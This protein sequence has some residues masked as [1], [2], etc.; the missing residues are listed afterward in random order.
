MADT[1]VG[2]DLVATN[3]ASPVINQ[4]KKSLGGL[5]DAAGTLSQGL[6]GLAGA[7]GVGSIVAI[8]TQIGAAAVQMT[9]LAERSRIVSTS[10]Q[11]LAAS[12]GQSA[13]G[14][15][16]AMKRAS[17]G[18]ISEY[19]LM[20]AANKAMMLGVAQNAGE[21]E[22]ILKVA[23]SRGAAMGLT[24][25][26]AFDDL[27]TG[28][29][30]GSA[31][32]LDNLGITM[33]SL[34][35]A[36]EEYARALGKTTQQLSDQEKKQA[37]VNAVLK[38]SAA[39]DPSGLT[40]MAGGMERL[41]AA[42]ADL[43][44]A[45][46]QDLTPAVNG[47]TGMTADLITAA[48]GVLEYASA[49]DILSTSINAM[50]TGGNSLLPDMLDMLDKAGQAANQVSYENS[51][52][53]DVVAQSKENQLAQEQ[54]NAQRVA[55]E[56]KTADA[57]VATQ[58]NMYRTM[59]NLRTSV[60]NQLRDEGFGIEEAWE[61]SNQAMIEGIAAYGTTLQSIT[62]DSLRLEEAKRIVLDYADAV[63][64]SSIK[65]D[66]IASRAATAGEVTQ[67]LA[68]KT[69]EAAGALWKGSDAAERMGASLGMLVEAAQRAQNALVF[70]RA[71]SSL[72]SAAMGAIDTLGAVAAYNLYEDQLASL[73]DVQ[74]AY[75]AQGKEGV[76][77]EF[78]MQ[79]AV[80]ERTARTYA[81]VNGINAAKDAMNSGTQAATNYGSALGNIKAPD[82]GSKVSGALQSALNLNV[83]V[84]PADYM[85]R[86]DAANEN[87]RR[88]ASIMVE[89]MNGQSWMGEFANEVPDIY[90]QLLESQ[91]PSAA[92]AKLLT[93]FQKGLV[94]QLIDKETIMQQV[95]DALM[96]EANMAA[97]AQEITQ[98]LVNQGMGDPTQIQALVNQSMGLKAGQTGT[99]DLTTNVIGQLKSEDFLNG[100]KG[101]GGT[102]ATNWGSAF[103]ASVGENVPMALILILAQLVAPILAGNQADDASRTGAQ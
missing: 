71:A 56:Q 11:G 18:T 59:D 51:F 72:Q 40:N 60:Y 36:E 65:M 53:N 78:L 41:R 87:A 98:D 93:D 85:P 89:G 17:L 62:V 66:S 5:E 81:L 22:G 31:L 4:V 102:A 8:A 97:L 58:Q 103:L 44:V 90:A 80:E 48:N 25:A 2:I 26:Q 7:A 63:V 43:Q 15:L 20:L 101:A 39:L 73:A 86:P 75:I 94:P 69:N 42:I 96:G 19:D 99:G 32:I 83:G 88:L 10:M 49:L 24:T 67:Q 16:D 34:K 45:V 77:L 55:D 92:A 54:A 47:I 70:D 82:I 74:A 52:V 33:D 57:I 95:K 12:F 91:D 29:G 28:L 3:R 61:Q 27:V 68:M 23:M 79:A 1:R 64:E 21:L 13:D 30:R 6:G 76:E 84:N 35:S 14:M 37:M 9:E 50:A 46:G 100:V 38:E